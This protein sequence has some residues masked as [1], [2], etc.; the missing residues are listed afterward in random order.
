MDDSV[1]NED[2]F[3]PFLFYAMVNAGFVIF[4]ATLVT[5]IEVILVH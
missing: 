2:L 4:G 5:Y 1:Q 3:K